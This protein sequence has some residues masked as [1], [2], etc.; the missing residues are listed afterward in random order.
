MEL[1]L[2]CDSLRS[3]EMMRRS[4]GH[5]FYEINVLH[6]G[7][8]KEQHKNNPTNGKLIIVVSENV[9]ILRKS[10]TISLGVNATV[11]ATTTEKNWIVWRWKKQN[12]PTTAQVRPICMIYE[13]EKMP[14]LYESFVV[15]VLSMV[16]MLFANFW[17]RKSYCSVFASFPCLIFFALSH[18]VLKQTWNAAHFFST[19]FDCWH[20]RFLTLG[21]IHMRICVVA[22]TRLQTYDLCKTFAGFSSCYQVHGLRRLFSDIFF[23]TQNA[24]FAAWFPGYRSESIYW[25]NINCV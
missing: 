22:F 4:N 25:L 20:F 5:A 3:T 6:A 13:S 2:I 12:Q 17:S 1:A 19:A 11:W 10:S 9:V 21:F 18:F 23:R 15:L 7:R 24:F 16:C 14:A 8:E